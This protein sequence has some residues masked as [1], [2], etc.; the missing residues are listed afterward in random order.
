MEYID[1]NKSRAWAHQLLKD[2]LQRRLEEDGKYPDDLYAAFRA[3]PACKDAFVAK[4]LEDNEGRCCYCMASILGTTLEHVILNSTSDKQKYNEYYTI[5]SD[6][7]KENMKL[8]KDFLD[9][10]GEIP[11]FPH[12]IAYENLIP[13]CFGYLPSTSSKCCNNYRGEKFVY[14]LVFRRN[15]HTEVHYYPN[16]NIV[17]AEDPEEIIPTVTK[18]G[19]DCTELKCIRRIW[20]FLASNGLSAEEPNRQKTIITLITDLG[21]PVTKEEKEMQQMLINFK[22][23]EYW[24]LLSKYTYFND[25][26]KFTY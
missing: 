2:F 23:P 22:K 4:L 3:D 16:G 14:P 10:P 9:N 26:T 1:K 8:A 13:S 11:P 7:D 25:P 24:K 17:W 21:I 12:T 20:H 19:L 15:I 6:L 18:L 5:E